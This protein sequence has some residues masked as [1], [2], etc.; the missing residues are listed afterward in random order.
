MALGRDAVSSDVWSGGSLE[1]MFVRREG[2]ASSRLR[3]FGGAGS[4]KLWP[5]ARSHN[6]LPTRTRRR[7]ASRVVLS[8]MLQIQART[9]S[10]HFY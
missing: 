6:G 9:G 7:L 5:C 8:T 3:S 1:M 2:V 4:A 10:R